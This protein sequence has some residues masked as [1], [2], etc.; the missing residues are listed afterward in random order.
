MPTEVILFPFF[1]VSKKKKMKTQSR[2][3]KKRIQKQQFS[4]RHMGIPNK[5]G[6]LMYTRYEMC[7]GGG[8]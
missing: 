1:I 2:T 3:R 7:D 5:V 4:K 8:S 6:G